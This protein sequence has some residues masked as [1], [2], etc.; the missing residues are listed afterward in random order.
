M[1]KSRYRR[2]K[3]TRLAVCI[4]A[5][6]I[7]AALHIFTALYL[8]NDETGDGK[9]YS[10]MAVTLLEQRVYSVDT[11]PPYTPT[12]IR[13][14]GYPIFL[15]GVYTI[16]GHGNNTAVRVA[17]GLIFSV[18]CVFAALLAFHWVEGK[19]RRRRKAAVLA[20]LL[21]AICPVLPNFSAVILTEIVTMFF[22]AAMALA[23]TY[24]IKTAN[25]TASWV[26]W[27][28]AGII[29][30]TAVFIRPDCGLFALGLGLTLVT[31]L[32]F[33]RPNG[34]GFTRNIALTIGKGILFSIAFVLP[35]APWT[36]RNE[37][38][39]GVF[40]PLA[41]THAE[42]PGEFVP[43]G[44]YLWVRTW[45]DDQ[46]YIPMMLWGLEQQRIKIDQIPADAFD[47]DDERSQV[48]ALINQYN[49]S[50]PEHPMAKDQKDAK[51]D[52]DDGDDSSAD[53]S[54]DNGDNGD[55]QSD[56]S[57][58]ADQPEQP[59]ELNLK[60]S[61]EVDTAFA[62]IA[63]ERIT[64]RPMH[65][66]L[67]LPAE[68]AASMW[69]DTHS[70]YYPFSGELFPTKDL[71]LE[72]N[73]EFWLP[74]FAGIV[75]L[76]TLLAAA[77]AMFLLRNRRKRSRLWLL[78]ILFLSVPRIAFFGTMENPEPRYLI[79]LFIFAAI[80]GGIALAR[81]YFFRRNHSLGA[82][83]NFSK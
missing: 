70:D 59:E 37:R 4:L 24:G 83:V 21:T 71:D 8:A 11:Q 27:G 82:G 61:P 18:T 72:I 75:W 57:D 28:A 80:L 56:N 62:Q 50:D 36:I 45:I 35:L 3:D 19:K 16:F 15:A 7:A 26:W 23:A 78:M 73:Q 51:A 13:L 48:A 66:Y 17:Q 2:K 25:H 69:F 22:L 58:Q 38:V 20:F 55:D 47:S 34:E 29:A 65:F 30:G 6:L 32:F 40:Q 49:N 43:R 31:S 44:Y 14:P 9:L 74:L 42:A 63:Q 77:G 10:Q 5:F 76:Y 79:E 53:N 64:R 33:N 68:R 67:T 41:P 39:F 81:V 1:A 46:R 60:V 54:D 52:S 12:L